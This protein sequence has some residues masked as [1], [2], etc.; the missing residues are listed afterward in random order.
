MDTPV[1]GFG[2]LK[3][4]RFRG[5]VKPGERFVVLAKLLKVRS[6]MLTS[7]FQCLVR[8]NLVCEGV[9]MGIPLPAEVLSSPQSE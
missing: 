9:I 7:Q 2:G 1:V 6:M 4:V 5:V 8:D 3:D